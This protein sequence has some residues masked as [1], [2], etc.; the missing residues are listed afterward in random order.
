[1]NEKFVFIDRWC[2][3]MPDAVPDEDGNI[4]LISKKSFGPLEVL[5]Q[6]YNVISIF[7]SNRLSDWVN[8]YMEILGRLASGLPG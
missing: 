6:I 5:K 7:K 1:M 4:V 3:T 8:F 2:Y